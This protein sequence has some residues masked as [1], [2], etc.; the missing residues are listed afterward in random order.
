MPCSQGFKSSVMG[1]EWPFGSR[2]GPVQLKPSWKGTHSCV[3]FTP[4]R[5]YATTTARGSAAQHPST[6]LKDH[7]VA[8]LQLQQRM[9]ALGSAA[10]P[11][12]TTTRSALCRYMGT[13][14][15][16]GNKDTMGKGTSSWFDSKKCYLQDL[17]QHKHCG[18]LLLASGAPHQ[19]IRDAYFGCGFRSVIIWSQERSLKWCFALRAKLNIT[20][21]YICIYMEYL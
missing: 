15:K 1:K 5:P 6:S 16:A 12:L 9:A 17:L 2:A 7:T 19:S 21:I 8:L 14:G 18:K 11:T 20:W 4:K 10:V 3:Q 13:N